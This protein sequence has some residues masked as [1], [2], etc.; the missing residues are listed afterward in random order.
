M[1][2]KISTFGTSLAVQW[3]RLHFSTAGGRG[4]IPAQGTKIPH[5][6][7]GAAPSPQK[8]ILQRSRMWWVPEYSKP[9]RGEGRG[10]GGRVPSTRKSSLSRGHTERTQRRWW[11]SMCPDKGLCGQ[12]PKSRRRGETVE[13]SC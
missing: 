11:R 1:I 2:I 6:S 3:L 8:H 9:E 10:Q 13:W 4:W 12:S 5:T 7:G